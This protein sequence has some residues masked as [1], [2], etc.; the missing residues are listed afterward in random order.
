MGALN[1]DGLYLKFGTER[2]DPAMGG[3]YY[4]TGSLRE[5]EF[6]LDLTTLADT[7]AILEGTDT[8]VLPK[9]YQIE[10]VETTTLTVATGATATLNLGLIRTNRSTAY[11]ADGLIAVMPLANFSVVGEKNVFRAAGSS[12]TSATTG[13]GALIG[14]VLANAGHLVGDWD[15]AAFTAGVIKVRIKMFKP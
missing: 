15:T 9:G 12:P 6:N 13:T 4:S 8:L 5:I 10:E 14:T 11:D 2:A 7:S 1:A 3:E